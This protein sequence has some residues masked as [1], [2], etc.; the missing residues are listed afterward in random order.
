MTSKLQVTIPKAVATRY[1]I[2]PGS[3]IQWEP[4]GDVI[5]VLPEGRRPPELSTEM[6]LRLFDDA[7]ARQRQRE[8]GA[9]SR[10]VS[11]QDRGWQRKDLYRR[12]GAD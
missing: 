6:R 8:S 3:E 11:G 12:G 4:A 10:P 5:R 1:A 9:D 7:T 2:A